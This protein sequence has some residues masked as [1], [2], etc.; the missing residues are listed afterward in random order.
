MKKGNGIPRISERLHIRPLSEDALALRG[1][2]PF[3][4]GHSTHSESDHHEKGRQKVPL[5]DGI[6]HPDVRGI[7]SKW[8]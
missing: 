5:K 1:N 3:G 7:S 6:A 2:Q 8:W 4:K